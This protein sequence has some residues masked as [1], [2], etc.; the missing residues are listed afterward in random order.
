MAEFDDGSA[1]TRRQLLRRGG[2]AITVAAVGVGAGFDISACGAPR[3]GAR[4]LHS[5]A[6]PPTGPVHHFRSRP[7]LLVPALMTTGAADT[8]GRVF[9]GPG[10]QNGLKGGVP[11]T[12]PQQGPMIVDGKGE[13]VWFRP[14]SGRRWAANVRPQRYRGK[15]VLTWWEG[16]VDV[17]IGFGRG[18]GVILDSA[19]REVA[20]V[21]AGNG[22]DADLHEFTLTPRGTALITC[23]PETV[24]TD[25]SAV[26]GPVGGSALGS[27][28]QEI[29]ISTGR[30]LLEWHGL[31][32]IPVSDS[33]QP[34]NEPYDYLHVNSVQMLPDGNLLI[35]ARATWALYKL[36]VGSGEVIWQLGGKRDD[37]RLG[38]DSRFAWQHHGQQVR[39]GLVTVFD[40]GAG[41]PHGQTQP[42]SRALLLD[43]DEARHTAT[44]SHA[45]AHRPRLRA[46]SM[47]SVQMLP[48][49]HVF[50]GWGYAGHSSAFT[51]A[52]GVVEDLAFEPGHFSYR[53]FRDD[54]RAA[55]DEPPALRVDRAH[56]GA[57]LYA[58]WNGATEVSRWR[59]SAGRR[60]DSLRPIGIAPRRGFETAIRTDLTGG[61][62]A[63]TAVDSAGRRLRDSR[64]VR[65]K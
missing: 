20:R 43:V 40:N 65:L 48:D 36:S 63:V 59:V 24:Q 8:S 18:E 5:S 21:R 55:A 58:S 38:A 15:Q 28:I 1:V 30:V 46:S 31:D 53:S 14:L 62:A 6:P 60:A 25:L 16:D 41:P 61:Y 39:P 45:Y 56:G 22:R 9:I 19:Y 13:L 51:A 52:G 32:H 57:T 33:Y 44:L 12:G 54:W 37:Y 47:G 35:S 34:Y 29:D 11:A 10:S 64:A 7:D 26:G 27:I 3:R 50:V 23:Y 4:R 17:D 42:Q 49:G 2:S